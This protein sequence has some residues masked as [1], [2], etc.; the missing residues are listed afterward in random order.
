MN[1]LSEVIKLHRKKAG[2]TQKELADLAGLGKTVIFDIEK[3]K[4]TV[5]FDTILKVLKILNIKLK[6]ESPLLERDEIINEES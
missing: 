6:V 1:R 2:L 5:Q 3:N 4:Q